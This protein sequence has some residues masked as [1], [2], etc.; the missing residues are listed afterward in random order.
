MI[1]S[2]T[3]FKA[4]VKEYM[5]VEAFWKPSKSAYFSVYVNF[6]LEDCKS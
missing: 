1:V 4:G 3:K 2:N 5:D 6:M